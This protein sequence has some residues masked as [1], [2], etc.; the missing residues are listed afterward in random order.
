MNHSAAI[1]LYSAFDQ[2]PAHRISSCSNSTLAVA[3]VGAV[4]WLT[5]VTLLYFGVIFASVNVFYDALLSTLWIYS[6]NVQL[7]GD[8]TDPKHMS[9]RP[10][11]PERSCTEVDG[12][13]S[14]YC[15]FG[16]ILF[17]FAILSV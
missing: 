17:A 4:V 9:P 16:K 10:W 3:I 6:A 12:Q 8:L 1:W 7:S 2:V 11:Y 5:K 15:T 13:K 14:G